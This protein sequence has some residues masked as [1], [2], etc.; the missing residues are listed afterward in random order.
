MLSTKKRIAQ[1]IFALN[2]LFMYSE[3]ELNEMKKTFY[4][5]RFRTLT[6]TKKLRKNNK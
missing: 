3:D 5:Q 4:Q 2:C 6:K 1:R